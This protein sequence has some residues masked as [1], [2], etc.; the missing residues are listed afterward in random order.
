MRGRAWI[1]CCDLIFCDEGAA[2]YTDNYSY[3]VEGYCPHFL[4]GNQWRWLKYLGHEGD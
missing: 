3:E 4:T 1:C 2:Y